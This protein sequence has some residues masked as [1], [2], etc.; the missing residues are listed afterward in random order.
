M[1]RM[2]DILVTISKVNGTKCEI[3]L[4][5]FYLFISSYFYTPTR[6]I[7]NFNKRANCMIEQYDSYFVM[8]WKGEDIK[9]PTTNNNFEI[10]N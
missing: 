8:K 6:T 3:F 7:N 1:I 2:D 9:V 4:T 10:L 5:M